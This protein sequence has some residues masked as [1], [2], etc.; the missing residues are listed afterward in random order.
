MYCDA[1][2]YPQVYSQWIYAMDQGKKSLNQVSLRELRAEVK[3]L[4]AQKEE[5]N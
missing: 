1:V 4:T 2:P 5:S 3:N